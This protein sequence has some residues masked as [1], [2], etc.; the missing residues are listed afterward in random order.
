MVTKKNVNIFYVWE[1][2]TPLVEVEHSDEGIKFDWL[3]E[4]PYYK[5]KLEEAVEKFLM[6]EG[7]I[8]KDE[9]E[10]PEIKT[11]CDFSWAG[12]TYQLEFQLPLEDDQWAGIIED[13]EKRATNEK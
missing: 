5:D 10:I 4:A 2:D 1:G 9:N 12:R 13:G 3:I 11:L 7:H 6:D 8:G